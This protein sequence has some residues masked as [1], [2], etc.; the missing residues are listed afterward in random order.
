MAELHNEVTYTAREKFFVIGD[1]DAVLGFRYA[2][3]RG[4]VV[5]TEQDT[6][7]ALQQAIRAGVPIVI[8]TDAAAQMIREDVNAV[9]FEA[10][11]PIIVE[12]P[13]RLGP[14]E[15]RP[16]LLSLI[17]EAVGIHV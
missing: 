11:T 2:G 10:K 16:T 1:D 14:V 9:R 13:T 7:L 4:Q 3:L 17:R 5:S 12:I 6:R 8:I 15:G